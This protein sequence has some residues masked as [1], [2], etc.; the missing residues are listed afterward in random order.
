MSQ[1]INYPPGK[2]GKQVETL[3]TE[4]NPFRS[5]IISEVSCRREINEVEKINFI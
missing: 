5:L 4:T 2:V 1:K 3:P